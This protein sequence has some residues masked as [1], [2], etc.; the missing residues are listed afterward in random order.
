MP[1]FCDDRTFEKISFN[2]EA[3]FE[4]KI[5]QLADQIF[6]PKTIYFDIKKKIKGHN[7]GA[8]PDGF[9]IDMTVPNEPKLYIV[10]NEIVSHDPFKHI[11]IQMLKF[12]TSFEDDRVKVRNILMDEIQN[13]P[14]LLARVEEGYKASSFRNIDNYLDEAVFSDFRGLVIIDE[15]KSELHKVLEKINANI[16]VLELKTYQSADGTE[17]YEF[18]T[19]YEDDEEVRESPNKAMKISVDDRLQRRARRAT[20]DTIVVP[21]REDGFIQEFLGNN[22]W[23]SI[24]IG[25]AMKERIKFIAA[26][27]VA[28]ISAVTHVAKI[29]EIRPYRDTG[30][31]LVLFDGPAEEIEH[32]K[33]KDP[34]RSPQSPVYVK[35][36]KLMNT[37]NFDEAM[38][39]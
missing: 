1:I 3:D 37:S 17:A 33:L 14:N 25:A 24:R 30:K 29:K 4:A 34:K 5:V 18:D 15:A 19:L 11:G 35:Y 23:Y 10:E 20:S 39:E 22:Q 28:P 9:C 27:Q 36:S 8:I 12:V 7:I 32:K 26:Y 16:S 31:Y 38:I 21:A 6:G 2:K 13:N